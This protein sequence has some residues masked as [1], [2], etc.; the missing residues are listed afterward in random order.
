MKKNPAPLTANWQRRTIG[1]LNNLIAHAADISP[2]LLVPA[3]ALAAAPVFPVLAQ[4]SLNAATIPLATQILDSRG[5]IWTLRTSDRHA[6]RNGVDTGARDVVEL[7]YLDHAVWAWFAGHWWKFLEQWQTGAGQQPPMPTTPGLRTPVGL[8]TGVSC[9]GVTVNP[10]NNIQSLVDANLAGTTFCFT[11]GIYNRQTVAP[12]DGDQFV[13]AFDGTNAAVLDGQATATTAFWGT[14]NHVVIKNLKITNYNTATQAGTVSVTGPY[15]IL[16]SNEISYA[17][18]GSGILVDNHALVIG[19]YLHH[20]AEEGYVSH[21]VGNTFDS[22]EID[23]NNPTN[24]YWDSGEQGG[25]KA[26]NNQY[27][28]FWYNYSHGNGGPGFWTDISNIYTSYWYNKTSANMGAGIEHEI[29]YNASI[30]GNDLQGDGLDPGCLRSY[31]ACGE[32]M[33]EN[34]GGLVGPYAGM[35]EV[36]FNKIK[37][38]THGRAISGRQQNRGN[39]SGKYTTD[40]F[41]I[42]NV[43]IHHNSIDMTGSTVDLLVGFADDTGDTAIF[44]ANNNRFDYNNYI[45]GSNKTPFFWTTN[46]NTFMQWQSNFGFDLHGKAQ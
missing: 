30:I 1:Y 14:A 36:A 35:I 17:S 32:V 26:A 11:A 29:S 40:P 5:A 46:Y 37:P 4:E 31:V 21:G 22:N 8:Q 12:K 13:G 10:R 18:K 34:S 23:T 7:W 28:T 19:N 43:W 2:R 27:L 42:R 3:L 41:W 15:L 44:R 38:G 24:G 6:L 9:S 39:G 33:I 20:N 45:L 25:G 16:Q